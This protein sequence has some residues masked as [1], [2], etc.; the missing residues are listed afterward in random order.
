V[1]PATL[2]TPPDSANYVSSRSGVY[3]GIDRGT[4][5][6]IL[7]P[8]RLET[9]TATMNPVIPLTMAVLFVI[10]PPAFAAD[11]C[12][13]V[14][15]RDI[16]AVEAPDSILKKGE[17]DSAITQYRVSKK[18]GKAVFCSHG[19]YCYPAD[20][21]RL[22]NCKVGTKDNY[23]DP[24]DIYYSV[25]V[26]RSKVPGATLRYDDLDNRL[27]QMGMCSA[28]ASNAATEYLKHP[29]SRC[30]RIVKSALEGNPV[31]TKALTEGDACQ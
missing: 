30:A 7:A 16:P 12:E 15:T 27:L 28:C 8:P 10:A 9:K 11:I 18:T 17:K 1:V 4:R 29:G 6:D 21:L 25:D 2:A 14:A 26:I 22:L 13:A 24:E 19:G 5:R 23:D 20:G 3:I 31:A